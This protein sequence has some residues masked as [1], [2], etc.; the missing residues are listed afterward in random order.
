[1]N[2]PQHT[3]E[4]LET[5][6]RGLS[7][8]RPSDVLD[9]R[10]ERALSARTFPWRGLAV[11]ACFGGLCFLTGLIVGNGGTPAASDQPAAGEAASPQPAPAA[12]SGALLASGT[13]R[14]DAQWPVAQAQMLYDIDTGPPVRATIRDSVEQTRWVDT[15]NNR[16]IEL[17]RPVREVS[18]KRDIPY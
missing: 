3:D 15:E 10:V 13:T 16:D 11:A 7:L 14:F 6:L 17:T 9:H 4:Q 5:M 18:F 12:A 1:M 2:E 8:R